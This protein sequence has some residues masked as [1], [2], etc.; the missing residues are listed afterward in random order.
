MKWKLILIFILLLIVPITH[1]ETYYECVSTGLFSSV[2]SGANLTS[3]LS[4]PDFLLHNGSSCCGEAGG[5]GVT[6]PGNC[7]VDQSCD[8][9]MYFTDY[10]SIGYY[11]DANLTATESYALTPH[12]NVSASD[13]Y[14]LTPHTN[15]TAESS[16]TLTPHTNVSSSDVYTL[17]PHTN[18]TDADI[19]EVINVSGQS[20]NITVPCSLINQDVSGDTDFCTDDTGTGS[21]NCSVDQSCDTIMYFTDYA[22]IGYYTDANLTAT[23]SY[24]L[25]PHTNRTD[26]DIIGVVNVSNSFWGINSSGALNSYD[27]LC[28]NCIG[29]TEIAELAD[30]DISNTLTCSD[31]VAGSEVVVDSE[32]DND[33]TIETN[34]NITI[35]G[36]GATL[37][38]DVFNST[39]AKIWMS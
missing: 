23:E 14:T 29:G 28:T 27:L 26:A 30:A 38:I 16:Y 1:S 34:H 13:I 12:T 2:F 20:F 6:Y 32:V 25:T 37:H 22:S 39:H 3:P 24:A 10:A 19:I 4:A 17:T 33:I 15:L 31:L 5:G 7:S 8:T 21:M 9:I 18:R 35:T 11:T 36:S